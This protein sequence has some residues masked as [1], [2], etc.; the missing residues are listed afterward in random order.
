MTVNF[1]FSTSSEYY[2]RHINDENKLKIIKT[3]TVL[4]QKSVRTKT[5]HIEPRFLETF[6]SSRF[7]PH[8]HEM[9]VQH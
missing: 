9:F 3:C 8:V 6:L 4:D 5:F 1:L 2:S 7:I